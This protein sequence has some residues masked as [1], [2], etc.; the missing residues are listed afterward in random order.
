M[1]KSKLVVLPVLL[2]LTGAG[3]AHATATDPSGD[4]MTATSSW[5]DDDDLVLHHPRIRDDAPGASLGKER[6]FERQRGGMLA[7]KEAAQLF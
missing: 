7:I 2:A 4:A 6:F 5:T 1:K 3:I